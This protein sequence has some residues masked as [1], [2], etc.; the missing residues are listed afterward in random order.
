M[1]VQTISIDRKGIIM[2]RDNNQQTIQITILQMIGSISTTLN[3]ETLIMHQ[4][5]ICMLEKKVL[6]KTR[7]SFNN[8]WTF[9]ILSPFP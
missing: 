3:D 7:T 6:E 2:R 8:I 4:S 9:F 1:K 5:R